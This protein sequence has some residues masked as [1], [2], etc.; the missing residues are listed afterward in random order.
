MQ[1]IPPL[2]PAV[3]NLPS[4]RERSVLLGLWVLMREDGVTGKKRMHEKEE[5]PEWEEG[6]KGTP[7]TQPRQRPLRLWTESVR[8]LP[9]EAESQR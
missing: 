2:K 5:S 7:R 9:R 1:G 6:S 8:E 3:V 4:P